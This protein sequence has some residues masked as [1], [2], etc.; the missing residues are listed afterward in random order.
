MWKNTH[1]IRYTILAIFKCTIHI[2]VQPI[3]RSF[4]YLLNHTF[5]FPHLSRHWQSPF[6]FL[7]L[8]VQLLQI[9]DI[10]GTIQYLS[11]CDWLISLIIMS[12]RF[13]HVVACHNCLPF[14]EWLIFPLCVQHICS[15][16]HLSMDIWVASTFWLLWIMLLWTLCTGICLSPSF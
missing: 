8:W 10:S 11:F 3:S 4:S 16:M 12:S 5:P 7:F 9:A 14:S 2:V 15:S 13:I 6:Y 1:N